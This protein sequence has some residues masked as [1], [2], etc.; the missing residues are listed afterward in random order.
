MGGEV[1]VFHEESNVP[2]PGIAT[3]E[4]NESNTGNVSEFPRNTGVGVEECFQGIYEKAMPSKGSPSP[5]IH[6][7]E[8]TLLRFK[9]GAT[10]EGGV[11]RLTLTKED[12]AV[13]DWFVDTVQQYGATVKVDEMG[14]LFAVRP[15]QN[16]EIAPIGI[17]SHLDTQPAGGRYDGILGVQAGIEVLK[18]LHENNYTTYAP[19]AVIDWTNEEGAR[20]NTGMLSSAVWAG[21]VSLEDAYNHTDSDG[22]RFKDELANI[23]YLGS[24][25]ATHTANPLSAHFEYHI[26]Q[27]PLLEDEAKSVGVVTGVQGMTWLMVTVNG[28]CQHCGTTPIDRRADAL[29]AAA[30]MISRINTIAWENKGLTT[31][32][33][34]NS[35]PQ[36][37]GTIPGTVTFSV[38]IEHHSNET[39][40]KM[41]QNVREAC[42]SIAQG[43]S[44]TVDIKQIWRS[45]AVEFHKDCIDAVRASAIELVGEDGYREL[46][47][48]AGHDS[49]NTSYICPTAMVFIPSRSGISHHPSEYSTPEHCALGTQVLL[50]AV[51]RYDEVLRA[52]REG[53]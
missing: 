26:E 17:G 43:N 51:L 8:P 27:G 45:A 36:S 40:D 18:V 6:Y 23:G 31:V 16:S 38:D 10:P 41:A 1:F 25:K 9:W 22:L 39:L 35:E 15:G 19:I 42:A 3:V 50:N 32:G 33:V 49:V 13:R 37:P 53:S 24:V 48:G 20:F 11:R 46:P 4:D 5:I 47:A 2:I 21:N 14:N 52:Q 44:C 29:L 7:E 30:Q 12:K 28:R 34:I